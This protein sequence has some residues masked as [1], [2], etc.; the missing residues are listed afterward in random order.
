MQQPLPALLTCFYGK[1]YYL[2]LNERFWIKD[3]ENIYEIDIT[4]DSLFAFSNEA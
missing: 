2:S 4:G 3:E 1:I